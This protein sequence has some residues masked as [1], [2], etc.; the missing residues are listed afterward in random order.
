ML[1]ILPNTVRRSSHVQVGEMQK[2]QPS[3]LSTCKGQLNTIC[4]FNVAKRT[5][6]TRRAVRPNAVSDTVPGS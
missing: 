3:L 5:L 4:D 2:P 1:A 6:G